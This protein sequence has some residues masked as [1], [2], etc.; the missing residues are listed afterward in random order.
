MEARGGLQPLDPE[1]SIRKPRSN[2]GLFRVPEE[3]LGGRL[4]GDGILVA[5]CDKAALV[6]ADFGFAVEELAAALHDFGRDGKRAACGRAE[7]AELHRSRGEATGGNGHCA[8]HHR[9]DDAAL[10]MSARVGELLH[11]GE[12][13]DGAVVSSRHDLGTEGAEDRWETVGE[14]VGLHAGQPTSA[15]AAWRALAG[16]SVIGHDAPETRGG[17]DEGDAR[18]QR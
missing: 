10:D 6:V 17:S 4:E 1:H 7:E 15:E 14:H 13:E 2:P 18:K 11:H 3:N 9:G 8:I 16:L 5:A 12:T